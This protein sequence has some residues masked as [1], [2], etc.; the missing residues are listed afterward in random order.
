MGLRSREGRDLAKNKSM[1][2]LSS[3]PPSVFMRFAEIFDLLKQKIK[4]SLKQFT[5]EAASTRATLGL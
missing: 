5:I 4:L 1:F 3:P 2:R